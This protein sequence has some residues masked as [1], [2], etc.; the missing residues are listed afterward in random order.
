MA[1][2]LVS[3][4]LSLVLFSTQLLKQITQFDVFMTLSSNIMLLSLFGFVGNSLSFPELQR[5]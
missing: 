5:M 1:D 2:N 4:V 3:I